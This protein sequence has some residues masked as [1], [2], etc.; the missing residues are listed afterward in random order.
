MKRFNHVIRIAVVA[1][2][3][4]AALF[5]WSMH[6]PTV[7]AGTNGYGYGPNT[8]KDGYVYGNGIFFAPYDFTLYTEPNDKSRPLGQ[9]HWSRE[10]R[11]N[12]V[13]VTVGDGERHSVA[14]DKTFF[15]FYPEMDV[16]MMAVTGDAE[17]GWVEVI[18]DQAR[19][20]TGWVQLKNPPK[21][22][23][24]GAEQLPDFDRGEPAHFGVYQ[25]WLEFMKLNAKANGV[26]WLSGVSE[27]N[28]SVRYSDA[29]DAKFIPMT[30]IRQLKIKH[31]RGNWM[32]VEVLDFERNTPIGWVRWRDDN[33]NLMVFPNISGQHLPIVTTTY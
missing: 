10:T 7:Q 33:G 27:Y 28:R 17:N 1:A 15:C 22:A 29:D 3:F 2:I 14:A 16:A 24:A 32:L 19:K 18:Y 11:T 9:F 30:I 23:V 26:Y 4:C 20:K 8:Y 12:S 21:E 31:V 5:A 6:V 13:T 25:T